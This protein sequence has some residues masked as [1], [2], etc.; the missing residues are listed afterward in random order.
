VI[1]IRIPKP[2]HDGI[3]KA[4]KTAGMT[5]SDYVAQLIIRGQEWQETIGEAKRLLTESKRAAHDNLIAEMRRQGWAP[6]RGS[7][8]WMTPGTV[9][10][11]GFIK[12][13]VE[14]L[15]QRITALKAVQTKR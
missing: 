5:L 15:E 6:L 13:E 9:P 1:A 10:T 7:P 12:A 4:A 14:Q 3:R 11:S 8:Y 2:M